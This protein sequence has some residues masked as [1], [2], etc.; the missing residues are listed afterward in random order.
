MQKIYKIML[1]III[2]LILLPTVSGCAE[3][4]LNN[5]QIG[6]LDLGRMVES[7]NK[8]GE[9]II[10]D[11]NPSKLIEE[12][13]KGNL[14]FDSKNI[15]KKV[16]YYFVKE[17]STN[18]TIIIKVIIIGILCALLKNLQDNFGEGTSE[19]A[20]YACYLLMVSFII[21]G[22]KEA[23]NVGQNAIV[24]MVGFMQVLIPILISLLAST[25]NVVS[26][27]ALYPVIML[28]VEVSSAIL[29][30]VMIPV[31]FLVAV[32][33]IIGNISDKIQ[34][35]RLAGFIKTVSIW[36]MGIILTVFVSVVTIEANLG[37]TIDGVTSKT[38][39]FAFSK[40]I[41]V[42][43]QTLSDAVETVL[44]CSLVIKSSVGVVGMILI[45]G[46]V[47]IPLIKIL[48]MMIIYKFSAVLIE[49]IADSRMVRCLNDIGGTLTLLFSIVVA[50]SFMF[51]VAI[52]TLVRMGN[53]AAMIR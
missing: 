17:I 5:E 43:G 32:L 35:S 1:I 31:V 22:F 33:S 48:A 2:T 29:G 27:A 39:K 16:V 42:V 50:V 19:I 18:I 11:F 26:T 40:A 36:V 41:P 7:F 13:S 15:M 23:I 30:T 28:V 8:D 6:A 25:G 9:Q 4:A 21:V 34:L 38:A 3:E 20:F 47:L 51:I 49:P 14:N 24:G 45:L 52:T 53:V 37:A 44:G 12:L 10:P 46:I